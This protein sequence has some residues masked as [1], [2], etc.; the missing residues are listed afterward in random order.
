MP[1]DLTKYE[2]ALLLLDFPTK[3]ESVLS[4]STS[5]ISPTQA[6]AATIS[7]LVF[8]SRSATRSQPPTI[9]QEIQLEYPQKVIKNT[10]DVEALLFKDTDSQSTLGQGVS[11]AGGIPTTSSKAKQ[12][13]GDFKVVGG[14]IEQHELFLAA[15]LLIKGSQDGARSST[16]SEDTTHAPSTPILAAATASAATS[17]NEQ[18]QA[19]AVKKRKQKQVALDPET[20]LPLEKTRKKQAEVRLD[21]KCDYCF[22]TVTPMW[23]H[24]PPGYQDLCNKVFMFSC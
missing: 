5:V 15:S 3:K 2:D 12:E 19:K 23:R 16:P 6:A 8:S 7:S 9:Q 17:N 20:G 21:R 22:T 14:S 13:P 4:Q 1:T 11:S 18:P 10:Q 24:G